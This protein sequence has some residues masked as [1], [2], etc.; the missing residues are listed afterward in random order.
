MLGSRGGLRILPPPITRGCIR[1]SSS[2]NTAC[3]VGTCLAGV[4]HLWPGMVSCA[5]KLPSKGL[6]SGALLFGV[7]GSGKTLVYL[8]AVRRGLEAGRGANRP[9]ARD[10]A[11]PQMVSGPRRDWLDK[12]ASARAPCSRRFVRCGGP[13]ARHQGRARS[14]S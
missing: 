13:R 9:C 3:S 6:P 11:H 8:R 4:A 1:R 2:I 10:W 7:T 14:L 12:V 5:V